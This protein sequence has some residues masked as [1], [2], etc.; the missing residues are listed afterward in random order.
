MRCSP[1]SANAVSSHVRVNRE[2][3]NKRHLYG[4]VEDSDMLVVA[5]PNMVLFPI[6]SVWEPPGPIRRRVLQ[7]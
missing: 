6:G 4:G 3:I 7:A 1:L 5:S 2:S